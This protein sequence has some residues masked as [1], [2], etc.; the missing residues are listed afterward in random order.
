MKFGLLKY[1]KSRNI[2]DQVQ[3]LAA[4]QYLPKTD[5]LLDRDYLNEYIGADTKL[6]LNGWFMAIPKHWPPSENITPLLTS[7]HVTHD[8]DANK[9][10]FTPEA[11]RFYEK[12]GPVGC[13]DY[14]TLELMESKGIDAYY[15][16]CLT[17]TLDKN[18]FISNEVIPEKIY[19]VDVLYKVGGLSTNFFKKWKWKWL[20]RQIFPPEILEK[21]EIISQVVPK[22]TTE[23]EKFQIARELLAKY[24]TANM[25]FTS[26]IHCALPCTAFGTKVLFIDGGLDAATDSTRLNGIADYFNSVN[27]NKVIKSYRGFL[28]EFFK[29]TKFTN[30]LDIDWYNLPGSP[31]NHKVVVEKL[32]KQ[33]EDFVTTKTTA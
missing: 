8:Y 1:S 32:K 12:Y 5:I 24:S 19:L 27:V 31:D 9:K 20:L 2:G 16:G 6:I 11:L 17:L 30:P 28:T 18:N 7:F 29:K 25:V 26:R 21:A 14:F 22:K 15:S 10:L 23:E 4:E 13:R 33:C 3:S